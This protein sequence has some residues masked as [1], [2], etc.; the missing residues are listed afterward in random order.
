MRVLRERPRTFQQPR[1]AAVNE[2]WR[3]NAVAAAT[4]K[5]ALVPQC[6]I[7]VRIHKQDASRLFQ[8]RSKRCQAVARL[9][10]ASTDGLRRSHQADLLSFVIVVRKDANANAERFSQQPDSGK[11]CRNRTRGTESR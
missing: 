10:R 7:D 11:L 8:H 6:L 3:G 5:P 9:P 2:Q 1:R 4:R